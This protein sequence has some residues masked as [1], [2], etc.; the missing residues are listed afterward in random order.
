[1]VGLQTAR[2]GKRRNHPYKEEF[3]MH[4]NYRFGRVVRN[5]LLA[6][7]SALGAVSAA[8]LVWVAAI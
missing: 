3:A 7:L 6:A 1:M 5:T 2:D 8:T 4:S